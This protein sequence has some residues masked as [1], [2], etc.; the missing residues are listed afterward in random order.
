MS[1]SFDRRLLLLE[2]PPEGCWAGRPPVVLPFD[3]QRA[4]RAIVARSR[5]GCWV[6]PGADRYEA[7]FRAFPQNAGGQPQASLGPQRAVKVPGAASR[8]AAHKKAA[9]TTRKKCDPHRLGMVVGTDEGLADGVGGRPTTVDSYR[10]GRRS[11]PARA[12]SPRQTLR[13]CRRSGMSR[14]YPPASALS[15]A[16]RA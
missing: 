15:T 5:K 6:S 14:Y 9:G 16:L 7:L 8:H 11:L 10:G 12:L 1:S 3:P 2:E 4:V 13:S